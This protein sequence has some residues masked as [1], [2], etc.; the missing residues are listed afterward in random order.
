MILTSDMN[1]AL[2]TISHH[3]SKTKKIYYTKLV[4]MSQ[5]YVSSS[6]HFS[7]VNRPL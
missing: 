1:A 2:N 6:L 5:F 7:E 3:L 4:G